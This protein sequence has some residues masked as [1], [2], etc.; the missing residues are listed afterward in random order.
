LWNH[1]PARFV[2]SIKSP[3]WLSWWFVGTSILLLTLLGSAIV[4]L[5]IRALQRQK[6]I[7]EQQ[8]ADRTAELVT[9][10]QQLE[11]IA[12]YD[13]L[14]RTP[15]RR[16]FI[17]EFRKRLAH[18]KPSD[19]FTLLLVDLDFF[20]RVNDRYGHDAGDAVLIETANRLKAEVRQSDCVARL[21][22]DEFA[23]L[24]FSPLDTAAIEAICERLL[25]NIAIPIRHRHLTLQIGCS[26]GI[27]R[28]PGDGR[29]Q[30]ALYKSADRA[31][32]EAK[33]RSRNVFCWHQPEEDGSI[34]GAT[35][36]QDLQKYLERDEIEVAFQPIYSVNPRRIVGFEAL[37]RWNHPERGEVE[38]KIFIPL[39]EETGLIQK[40]SMKVWTT[41][42]RRVAEWNK[43]WGSELFVSVNIS[44]RQ[45]SH[46]LLLPLILQSLETAGLSPKL[47]H[48]EITESVLLL[49]DAMVERTLVE[50]RRHGIGVSLDDFGTGYSSLSYL[51]NLSVDELK[52]DRSFIQG[53][54][55]DPRKVELVR[56]VLTLGRTLGKRVIGEG[57]D[58]YEQLQILRNLG[59][60][61]VQGFLLSKPLPTEMVVEVLGPE[62]FAA[63]RE[64]LSDELMF[65]DFLTASAPKRLM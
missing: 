14:T 65:K 62:M 58:S 24:L 25:A 8:V 23:I 2:F 20:K 57:V 7:L 32:Y 10:H 19:S 39:A 59:C 46:P 37:A 47:L 43:Q 41:A 22:G 51:L 45:F 33:Q 12:Y 31:L 11:E 40:L 17:E 27:A 60:E 26:I 64:N 15:N 18:A 35:L 21:G 16:M 53:L 4:Q 9:S 1:S 6:K 38:P 63:R 13:V 48:L 55:F 3:W 30:E 5:R 54:E 44:I 36:E 52:I 28:F 49:D 56:T 34:A 42:C 29:T 61:Y 50:A